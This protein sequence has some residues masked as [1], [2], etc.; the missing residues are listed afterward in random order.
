M[1]NLDSIHRALG[2]IEGKL[3]GIHDRINQQD[4]KITSQASR[5]DSLHTR[6]NYG[7]G[8]IGAVSFILAFFKTKL[9]ELFFH[10]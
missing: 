5:L 4:A 10:G 1:E 6:V 9:L 2:R 8:A 3:D 7:L